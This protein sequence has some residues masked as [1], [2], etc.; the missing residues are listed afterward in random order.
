MTKKYLTRENIPFSEV[1][2]TQDE[3]AMELVR[4]WGYQ[5]APV[6]RYGSEHWNG[7]KLDYLKEIKVAA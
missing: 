7:F 2:L 4:S 6:V 3:S 5:S 1:D